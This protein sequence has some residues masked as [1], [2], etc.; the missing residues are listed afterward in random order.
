MVSRL[1]L[2]W[3]GSYVGLYLGIV[4]VAVPWQ[5]NWRQKDQSGGYCMSKAR[6]DDGGDTSGGKEAGGNAS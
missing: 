4:A 6:E 1:A 2:I 3:K 5:W